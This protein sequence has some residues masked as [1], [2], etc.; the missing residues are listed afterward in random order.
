MEDKKPFHW[1]GR[2]HSEETKAKMR[3][4]MLKR[5]NPMTIDIV[6]NK[7]SATIIEKGIFSMNK[8]YKWKGGDKKFR[9]TG[10]SRHS[11]K[12]REFDKYTCQDCGKKQSD[13]KQKLDVHYIIDYKNGGTNNIEN[14]ISLCRSCHN[15]RRGHDA[16]K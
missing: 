9:G 12:R 4:A 10:W 15:K 7:R 8:N 1:T 16:C 2:K 6:K 13:M 11:E 5:I 14:L 3:E